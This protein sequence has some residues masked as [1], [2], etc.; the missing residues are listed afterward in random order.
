MKTGKMHVIAKA[1][2]LVS[3]VLTSVMFSVSPIL[4]STPKS[5]QMKLSAATLFIYF[6]R[7]KNKYR[8]P[9]TKKE[10]DIA[11]NRYEPNMVREQSNADVGPNQENSSIMQKRL[12]HSSESTNLLPNSSVVLDLLKNR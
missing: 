10:A 4:C 11:E 1:E 6:C 8:N 2:A 7:N 12:N 9:E 3:L 5:K